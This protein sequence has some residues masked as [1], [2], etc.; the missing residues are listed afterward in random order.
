MH[1]ISRE[2]YRVEADTPSEAIASWAD[3][4]LILSE[5]SS[6]QFESIEADA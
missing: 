3:G 6:M 1:G 4:T 5:S 2:V